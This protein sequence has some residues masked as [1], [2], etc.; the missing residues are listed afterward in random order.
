MA[1]WPLGN[2]LVPHIPDSGNSII[3]S[4]GV[5]SVARFG[6]NTFNG[7]SG[8][9]WIPHFTATVSTAITKLAMYTGGTTP[10]GITLARMALFT[11]ATDGSITK[12]AQ[13][14]SDNTIGAATYTVYERVFS[15]IGGFPSS[16]ALVPGIRYALGFL[17]VATTA[18]QISGNYIISGELAPAPCRHITGQA[19]IA[20]SY[21]VA[22]IPAHWFAMY[23]RGRP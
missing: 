22:N 11:V 15:T 10:A 1:L 16:Y 5:E 18:C 19:D 3:A 17:Q 20:A 2:D 8:Q 7:V 6:N 23:Q 21:A 14:A 9:L 13:T 12:V 4:G